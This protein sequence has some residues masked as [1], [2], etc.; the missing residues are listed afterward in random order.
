PC[1]DGPDRSLREGRVDRAGRAPDALERLADEALADG[2]HDLPG[3]RRHRRF[4]AAP[5]FP[6]DLLLEL[7]EEPVDR[8]GGAREALELLAD[9]AL[10]ERGGELSG[11]RGHRLFHAAPAF[12]E[13]LLLELREEPVDR[14]GGAREVFEL[15]ADE[16]LDERGHD[17]PG[18]RRHRL[19]HA[20]PAFAEDLLLELREEPVDRGGGAREALELLADGALE[21]RGGELSGERGHRLFH[22]AP[23]FAEDLLLE[24]REEPVDRGG[25]AREV[26]ELLADEA[27][28]ERGHDLPGERRHRLFHAAPAFAED[29]LLELREE[30]V[31]R[32]GGAR[33]VFELLADEALGER[34]HDLPGERGH[35]LFRAAPAFAEGL[36][37]ELREEPVG[38]GGG[39]RASLAL[40]PHDAPDDHGPHRPSERLHRLFHAAPAFAEDLLLELREELVDRGGGARE[41]L[42]L[43]ADEALGQRRHD[44]PGER[45]DDLLDDSPSLAR[46][47]LADRRLHRF[48]RRGRFNCRRLGAGAAAP[49]AAVSTAPPARLIAALSAL[50]RRTAGQVSTSTSPSTFAPAGTTVPAW[51][52]KSTGIFRNCAEALMVRAMS[53][54]DTPAACT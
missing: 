34:G 18:E 21:E 48:A 28:D 44:L 47:V 42:K 31:D 7:R 14:G 15:L 19:F 12:A 37:L 52:T 36:V 32:G 4:H 3:E 5:A 8:G 50:P 24:L 25:G 43:L 29:L 9:G 20:V 49:R 30:P 38:G 33:E 2:R 10:E 16:A 51:R 11:E 41:A 22:A 26:F 54:P 23:A 6:E 35:R 27:L 17:L 53:T 45:A 40:P 46:Q 39:A 1:Q 13:D